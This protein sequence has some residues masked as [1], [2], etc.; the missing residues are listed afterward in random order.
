[1]STGRR[2]KGVGSK[3]HC[4]PAS[5]VAS[6]QCPRP[7]T[8]AALYEGQHPDAATAAVQ[9]LIVETPAT[10][11]P[12]RVLVDVPSPM[13]DSVTAAATSFTGFAGPDVDVHAAAAQ[14][15]VWASSPE[16]LVQAS[17]PGP[18]DGIDGEE[19]NGRGMARMERPVGTVGMMRMEEMEEMNVLIAL[20]DNEEGAVEGMVVVV[21]KGLDKG[22]EDGM[23]HGRLD[24]EG[25]GAVKGEERGVAVE[26]DVEGTVL[27]CAISV[28]DEF[29]TYLV[30]YAR[31]HR[32]P[33][34]FLRHGV[35]LLPIDHL[36]ADCL[37][38]HDG[39]VHLTSA[40]IDCR[41][42]VYLKVWGG[43]AAVVGV[44][45]ISRAYAGQA[46]SVRNR[47]RNCEPRKRNPDVHLCLCELE[48]Q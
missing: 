11:L 41:A 6:G 14:V 19:F 16:V 18:G 24:E 17:W 12:R 37:V 2:K 46:D 48:A 45:G 10:D 26:V 34:A 5:S 40:L 9:V 43:Q 38:F 8:P 35:G 36:A 3:P 25:V 15:L 31:H 22:L 27:G 33:L 30:S 28:T 7:K 1:M 4:E 39:R 23:H 42:A 13:A 32:I 47:E 44:S 29:D 21:D 20:E